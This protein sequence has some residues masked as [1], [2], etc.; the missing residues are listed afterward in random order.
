MEKITPYMHSG[1]A[2]TENDVASHATDIFESIQQEV[3]M[4]EQ[5]LVAIRPETPSERGP[6]D[7]KIHQR[8][9][10]YIQTSQ[11]RLYMKLKLETTAGAV[12]AITDGAGTCNLPGNSLF[13]RM[14]IDIGGKLISDLQCTH[15]NYKTYL[16]TLLTYSKEARNSHLSASGWDIDTS[17]HLDD[18][19]FHIVADDKETHADNTENKGLQTRRKIQAFPFDVMIPLHFDFFNC[20][21]L[22]PPGID[23][24]LKLIRA[25]DGFLMMQPAAITKTFRIVISEM[26]L[27]VPYITV[28]ANIVAHHRH[29][30]LTKPVLL[31][32]KKTE[33]RQ[34]HYPAGLSN[35]YIA[36]Q[37]TNRMPKSLIIGMVT[38]NSYNGHVNSNP[39][40]FQHFNINHV[41]LKVNNFLVPIEPYTPDWK[42]SGP[43][44]MRELRSFYDNIGIGTDNIGNAVTADLYKGGATLF[45]WDFSPDHCNG[46]HWHKREDGGH[47]DIDLKF[48]EATPVSITVLC[49][50]VYDALVAI[51]K[52][53]EVVVSY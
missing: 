25:E 34:H 40:N 49:F 51:E 48:K 4:K 14:E 33:V 26:K 44:Y 10:Q 5:H 46:Y 24:I 15:S 2:Y 9:D 39:Y 28:A 21:R 27:F 3:S 53:M 47:L 12:P 36:N 22:F 45:A 23:M 30:M 31:P 8:A 43:L 18:V 13:T 32:I 52:N 1:L 17:A 42:D 11:I 19:R 35:I 38:A 50:A 6:Y 20:D 7:F 41:Q 37:Y 16:E 29:L